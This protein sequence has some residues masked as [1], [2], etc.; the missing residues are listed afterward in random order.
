MRWQPWVYI[1][2]LILVVLCLPG[3]N[4]E[5]NHAMINCLQI[6]FIGVYT[7]SGIHKFN[8]N[9]L[10][11]TFT[12]IMNDLLGI[13]DPALIETIKKIGY[14]IPGIEI[15]SGLLLFTVKW[16]DIGVC[17]VL[18]SHL[19]IMF[20]ISPLG[21]NDNSILYPWN[22]AMMIFVVL[23][24]YKSENKIIIYS[25][26]ER[27][28]FAPV[29]VV[30][31]VWIL[32]VTNFLGYWDHYLSFSLYSDKPHNFFIAIEEGQVPKLDGRFNSY[33]V[34]YEGMT[35]GRVIDVNTWAMRELNVPFYPERRVFKKLCKTFC[36]LGIED[37]KIF[38]LEFDKTMGSNVTRFTCKDINE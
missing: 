30:L 13:N 37:D 8:P 18:L 35:G 16:R 31:L 6:I 32:P 20:Y 9:F 12:R 23:L 10:E 5:D 11:F 17:F 27:L 21:V 22:I 24:F 1:Y 7:W 33:F 34:N 14:I 15:L 25:H 36:Q 2:G 38:F 26:R 29:M 4:K 3:K 28:R 19:F